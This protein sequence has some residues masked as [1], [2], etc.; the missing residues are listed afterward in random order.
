VLAVWGTHTGFFGHMNRER[1]YQTFVLRC[2][3]CDHEGIYLSGH[4]HKFEGEPKPMAFYFLNGRR[5][6][7]ANG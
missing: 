7:A 3:A 4:I 5:L 1:E 2:P 6:L